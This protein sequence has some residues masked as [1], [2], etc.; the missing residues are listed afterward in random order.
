MILFPY[1]KKDYNALAISGCTLWLEADDYS[2]GTWLDKSGFGYH[3]TQPSGGAMPTLLQNRINGRPAVRFDGINDFLFN[4]S[5]PILT[6]ATGFF[7][8]KFLT[9][10]TVG[11]VWDRVTVG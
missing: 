10:G 4:N 1:N 11:R 3:C 5:F 6:A 2:L 9:G 7:V 8:G